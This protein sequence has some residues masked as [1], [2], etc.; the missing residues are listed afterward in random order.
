MKSDFKIL[1]YS[2]RSMVGHDSTEPFDPELKT[3]G[4]A[5]VYADQIQAL[6]AA[7]SRSHPTN[8]CRSV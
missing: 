2:Y 4:L 7:G 6:I 3:E 5:E 8:P 1:N